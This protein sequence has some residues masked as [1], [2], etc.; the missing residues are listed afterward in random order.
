MAGADTEQGVAPRLKPKT[1]CKQRS[2]NSQLARILH[3]GGVNSSVFFWKS[4]NC[5]EI[6]RFLDLTLCPIRVQTESLVQ[7]AG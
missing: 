4:I 7:Y 1:I 3:Q 5:R 6:E 2:R